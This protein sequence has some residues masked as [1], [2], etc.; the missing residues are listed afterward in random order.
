MPEID[1]QL[2]ADPGARPGQ[3]QAGQVQL[4]RLQAIAGRE[5][6]IEPR[7]VDRDLELALRRRA[8][9]GRGGLQRQARDRPAGDQQV[10]A[11][12]LDEGVRRLEAA[13]RNDGDLE[14]AGQI[15]A[16]RR[17]QH[18]EPRQGEG[19]LTVEGA[20][21]QAERE[22]AAQ[23]RGRAGHGQA[24]DLKAAIGC[25][26]RRPCAQ[27]RRGAEQLRRP[28]RQPGEIVGA[29]G[30]VNLDPLAVRADAKI[31]REPRAAIERQAEGCAQRPERWR[32]QREPGAAG[33]RGRV[34][35]AGGLQVQIL[36]VE[37]KLAEGQRAVRRARERQP[38]GEVL[39]RQRQLGGQP[40]AREA[41]GP[42][43]LD[44]SRGRHR[45]R[46]RRLEPLGRAAFERGRFDG[47]RQAAA[48]LQQRTFGAQMGPQ[49]T[50]KLRIE[51]RPERREVRHLEVGR[52]RKLAAF[53]VELGPAGQ[54]AARGRGPQVI[55]AQP[56]RR[57]LGHR[58]R[59]PELL[60]QEACRRLGQQA[61]RRP[62]AAVQVQLRLVDERD[63]EPG[64]GLRQSLG[65]EANVAGPGVERAGAGKLQPEVAGVGPA[66]QPGQEPAGLDRLEAQLQGGRIKVETGVE[67]GAG[68]RT[69]D[70]FG[71]ERE[72]D[73]AA[74]I[75]ASESAGKAEGRRLAEHLRPEHDL[76]HGQP[77][78]CH[79][80]QPPRELRQPEGL[81]VG[82]RRTRRPAQQ[83][84]PV[85]AELGN[86]D[87]AP[88]QSARRPRELQA[89]DL[90]PVAILGRN[91]QPGQAGIERQA[92]GEVCDLDPG[93]GAGQRALDHGADHALAG[94]GLREGER[95]AD[96]EQ[97]KAKRGR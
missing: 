27:A 93:V 26:R 36:G 57:G 58:Q 71:V 76:G 31:G 25:Q 85:G 7:G 50:R 4:A 77:V 78:E 21:G 41:T 63:L 59:Q 51:Q 91:R 1:A 95:G 55:D 17:R 19:Q 42:G 18:R 40:Q 43:D 90:E 23:R 84:D 75:A 68:G 3:L 80:R 15:L 10:P 38:P 12:R 82:R 83:P 86:L 2:A 13:A 46:E 22:I 60:A 54:I 16:E 34:E 69:I 20:L 56:L 49:R 29:A 28:G 44:R 81:V 52:G 61:R 11:L 24:L 33:E 66:A 48:R 67:G 74:V 70:P 89:L 79:R 64:A 47:E 62:Q 88:Q 5:P 53:E 32:V 97:D 35:R 6:G 8:Q 45:E 9:I 96:Q 94:T 14:R 65:I 30:E 73:R 37:R 87:P 92:A 72:H 39:R